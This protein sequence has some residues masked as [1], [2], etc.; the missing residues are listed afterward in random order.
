M[1]RGLTTNNVDA[2]GNMTD[3]LT[4]KAKA[5]LAAINKWDAT[6]IPS[7]RVVRRNLGPGETHQDG[8]SVA[9]AEL[10]SALAALEQ[11]LEGK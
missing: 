11:E 10:E 5:L 6:L 4:E 9:H 1:R 3:K 7:A 8:E 2:G